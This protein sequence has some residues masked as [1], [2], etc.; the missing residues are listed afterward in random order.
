MVDSAYT[1]IFLF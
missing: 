1:N